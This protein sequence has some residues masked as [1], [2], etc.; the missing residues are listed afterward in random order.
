[1]PVVSFPGHFSI[2]N[3]N[4]VLIFE[5]TYKQN[6][7]IALPSNINDG[8]YLIQFLGDNNESESDYII[9]DQDN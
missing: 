1:M 5:S 7:L 2:F 3:Y 6:E 9:I 4:G 8:L